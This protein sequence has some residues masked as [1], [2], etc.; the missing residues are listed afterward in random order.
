MSLKFTDD[1]FINLWNKFGSANEISKASGMSLRG[2]NA[3]RRKLEE[4]TGQI[5]A[6]ISPRS[7]DFKIMYAGNGV[8]TKVDL[9]N[10]VIMVAFT[11]PLP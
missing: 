6:G 2:V 1:E 3:R 9:E 8:R 5:L 7:P 11:H 4:K 10:G